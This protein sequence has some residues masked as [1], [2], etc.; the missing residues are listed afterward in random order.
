[1]DCLT[2]Q[3]A[4]WHLLTR[5]CMTMTF[6][7]TMSIATMSHLRWRASACARKTTPVW[8][9]RSTW[10]QKRAHFL[11]CRHCTRALENSSSKPAQELI[12]MQ[13]FDTEVCIKPTHGYIYDQF[14]CLEL[15][16]MFYI[17]LFPA[18]CFMFRGPFQYRSYNSS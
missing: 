17:I 9:R 12:R 5:K 14:G 4:S 8:Q 6:M 13:S 1:M 11:P 10:R 18:V 2:S 3:C 15:I 7:T 16:L